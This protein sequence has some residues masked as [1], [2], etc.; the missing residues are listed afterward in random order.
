MTK[1]NQDMILRVWRESYPHI[2]LIHTMLTD[3]L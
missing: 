2:K 1:E 3:S